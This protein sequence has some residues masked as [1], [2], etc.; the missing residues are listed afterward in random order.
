M[1]MFFFPA[2]YEIIVKSPCISLGLLPSKLLWTGGKQTHVEPSSLC[3]VGGSEITVITSATY[4]PPKKNNQRKVLHQDTTSR[5]VVSK[6]YF[7]GE[8]SPLGKNCS[9]FLEEHIFQNDQSTVSTCRVHGV[10]PVL[11]S[12][13]GGSLLCHWQYGGYVPLVE[14]F[15]T[16]PVLV[17]LFSLISR[18]RTKN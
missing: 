2:K 12:H 10:P 5:V 1:F 15:T 6:R 13:Q 8:F 7:F 16:L 18:R 14:K 3:W 11:R 4:S 9:H 17:C